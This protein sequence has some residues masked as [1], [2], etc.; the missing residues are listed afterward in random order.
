VD[1]AA[2]LPNTAGVL[3]GTIIVGA[4]LAAESATRQTYGRT[5]GAVAIALL[6]Y[7]LVHAYSSFAEHRVEQGEPLT[8]RGLARTLA[9]ELMIVVGASIP[10]LAVLICWLA[11]ARLSTAVNAAIY[12]SSAMIVVVEV[13]AGVSAELSG[14]DLII[15]TALGAVFGL[16]VIALNLT[17][18]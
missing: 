9:A 14:R 12:T 16:L 17:L 3:Y 1:N 18:R 6:L 4:L 13:V 11:G 5:V 15:Q 2:M 10:L 7:W 8:F